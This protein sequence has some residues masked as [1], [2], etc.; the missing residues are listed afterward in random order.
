MRPK[1]NST[2]GPRSGTARARTA[3]PGRA[4]TPTPRSGPKPCVVLEKSFW[5]ALMML[6]HVPALN[7]NG[8]PEHRHEGEQLRQ[9]SMPVQAGKIGLFQRFDVDRV[10]FRRSFGIKP[11]QAEKNGGQRTHDH[12]TLH[13]RSSV[14]AP[15]DSF[16]IGTNP[17]GLS[18]ILETMCSTDFRR[19]PLDG[20]ARFGASTPANPAGFG[21]LGAKLSTSGAK[22]SALCF[23]SSYRKEGKTCLIS[24]PT[25]TR[26]GTGQTNRYDYDTGSGAGWIWAVVVLV[27]IIALVA[28]GSSGTGTGTSVEGG[29]AVAPAA[30]PQAPAATE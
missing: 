10:L 2:A 26:G 18:I 22:R 6:G 4:R 3:P 20:S 25:V 7:S 16:H 11:L 1:A 8:K 5:P 14:T 30:P 17:S 23:P 19:L 12:E 9:S 21:P 24:I 27:A 15:I 29:E 28:I 13:P